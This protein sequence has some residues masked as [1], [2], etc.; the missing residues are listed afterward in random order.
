MGE[1]ARNRRVDRALDT[2]GRG[3]WIATGLV[4]L[5][6]VL[7]ILWVMSPTERGRRR[8]M[9]DLELGDSI[10]R[11]VGFLGAA[12]ARCPAAALSHL[13]PSFP[14]GWHAASVARALQALE[15]R[16]LER[17]IYPVRPR[18]DTGCAPQDGQ[19]EIGISDTG[20]VVW[21]ITVTG[22]TPI[23]LPAEITPALPDGVG[24]VR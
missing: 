21:Y 12:P 10:S 2:P 14:P 19:T 24:S 16:T 9:E 23:R 6:G 13:Q 8:V 17:W 22:K 3:V 20:R 18:T 5:A 11:V 7:V 1:L 4:L 15:E